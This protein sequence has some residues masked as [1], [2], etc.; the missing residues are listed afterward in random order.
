MKESRLKK[1]SRELRQNPFDFIV[2]SLILL[3]GYG[4]V[5]ILVIVVVLYVVFYIKTCVWDNA[6]TPAFQAPA[7]CFMRK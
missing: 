5:A 4:L 6:F 3:I 1:L 2:G 7:I